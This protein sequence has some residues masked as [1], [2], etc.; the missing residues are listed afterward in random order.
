MNRRV[1]DRRRLRERRE[2]STER[3]LP[4]SL[5][6]VISNPMQERNSQHRVG[7]LLSALSAPRPRIPKAGGAYLWGVAILHSG[8]P[9][10]FFCLYRA[11]VV[12][13]A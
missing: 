5:L 9:F 13:C 8:G 12:S 3:G 1:I 7:E 11:H 2:W 10:S 4:N 6:P